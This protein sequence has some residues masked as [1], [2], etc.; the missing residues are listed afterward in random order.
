[1]GHTELSS[2]PAY[3][4]LGRLRQRRVG[5]RGTHSV[6]DEALSALLGNRQPLHQPA[7][8]FCR[9]RS[10][11]DIHNNNNNNNN[12]N[13]FSVQ[14]RAYSSRKSWRLQFHNAELYFRTRP[15]NLCSSHG[16][17]ERDS[18]YLF[19]RISITLQRFNSV[20]LHDT[21]PVDLPDL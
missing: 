11:V 15:P 3:I 17:R 1:M 21:L 2:C 7:R 6:S 13:I 12:N 18:A 4:L 8:L 9:R 5:T 20:L 16:R 19:Q 14:V 10:G